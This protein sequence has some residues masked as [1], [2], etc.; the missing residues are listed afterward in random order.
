MWPADQSTV[1]SAG[2]ANTAMLIESTITMAIA[3]AI[4]FLNFFII[5][6]FLE[7]FLFAQ[8]RLLCFSEMYY[9]VLF[10]TFRN[11]NSLNA[12]YIVSFCVPLYPAASP[13]PPGHRVPQIKL[14]VAISP[15]LV[16]P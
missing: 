14:F 5:L 1:A 2:S 11:S 7:C 4:I 13:S 15:A 12:Q 3:K 9:E 6:S 10:I 16:S 8:R